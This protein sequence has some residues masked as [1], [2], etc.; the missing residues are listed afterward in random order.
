MS[1]CQEAPVTVKGV[2][3]ELPEPVYEEKKLWTADIRKPKPFRGNIVMLNGASF[4][5]T[6]REGKL[7]I[8]KA[9]LYDINKAIEAKDFKE[10]PL[11]EVIPKHY[12]EFLPLFSKVLADRLTPHRPII[13]HEVRLKEGETLSWGLLYTMSM[14]ELVVMK[15]WLEDNMTKGF[16]RQ[17]S[18]P[19]AA[20]SLVAK[21]PNG[22]L[23]F[24]INYRDIN[25][26]TIK[27]RYPLPLIQ[28]TL[29]LLARARV[30]TKLDMMGVYNLVQ[31]KEGDEHK[32]AF[33]TRYGLFE[34]LVMQ[35]GTTNSQADFQ[36]YIN[37]T[38]QKALDCFASAYLNDILIYSNSIEE[39]EEHVKWIMEHLL[40]AGLYMK[41]EKCEFHRETVKYLGL[42]LSTNGIS[43][44]PDKIDTVRNWSREKKTPI[45][46]LNNLFEVQQFLGLFNYYRTF[47]KGYSEIAEPL[48]RLT[49]QDVPFEWLED[50]QKAFEEMILKFTTAPTI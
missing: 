41:P 40:K 16:I 14:E 46:R 25:C 12:H 8:F 1:H 31:V 5:R 48:K 22:G 45:G 18:S 7:T 38:I 21:K 19:Y 26:K 3:E 28:E 13:D 11:E 44:D 50:H 32:L 42:I 4:F 2:T 20:P 49:K 47:I 9:S 34:P 35:F 30:Y 23:R 29:D 37:D 27:N 39:H 33:R 15:E 43:M 6:V 36:E 17:S 10:R 24:C